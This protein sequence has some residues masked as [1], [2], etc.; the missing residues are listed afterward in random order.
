MKTQQPLNPIPVK[1]P[2]KLIGI[3]FV[4]PLPKTKNGNRYIIVAMDYMTKWP[5]AK[6]VQKVTAEETV[7]F[8]YEEIICQ[9]GCPQE[10]LMDRGTHFNNQLVQGLTK[11]FQIQHLLSTPY[12]LQTNGLVERLNRT[13][14][15]SLAKVLTKTDEWDEYVKPVLF[16][17]RTS[18]QS[19]TKVTPFYLTY[20][21]EAKHPLDEYIRDECLIN[22]MQ[23]LIDVLPYER[24]KAINRIE[25]QQN[26][27]KA[28]HDLR[29]NK[30]TKFKIGDK[31]L[32]YKVKK[33]NNCL[34]S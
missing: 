25:D 18:K 10:I 6:P 2:F 5:E 7:K 12:H 11:K 3:D 17:Y 14:C 15:E 21:R 22:R 13:L 4:G 9:H 24:E 30:V 32:L 29:I 26:K 23:K 31:V 28:Y 1:A 34:E 27:Q 16:A 19:T 20:G 8:I 33:I